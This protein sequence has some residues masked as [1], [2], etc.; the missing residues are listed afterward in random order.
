MNEY[1]SLTYLV[2]AVLV[3]PASLILLAL[4][5]LALLK[6]RRALGLALTGGSLLLLLVL[7]LPAVAFRLMDTLE[8]PPLTNSRA[9]GEVQAVVILAG[10]VSYNAVDWGGTSV[11]L[12]TLQRLRYGAWLARETRLP[13]LVT[14]AAPTRGRP[15]E[16]AMMRD[17]LRDEFGV[18]V[19]WVEDRS[20]HTGDNAKLS[21]AMLRA[22]GVTRIALVTSAFHM[23]RAQRVFEQTGLQVVPA[24]TGYLG[25]AGGTT[26]P[27]HFVPNGDS[28]RLSYLAL[29]ELAANLMYRIIDRG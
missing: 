9:V 22:A 25:T 1:L 15:G 20:R 11:S 18:P 3:P 8:G 27:E 23:P 16:A 7:S 2:G 29:R 6:R 21:A 13:V 19:R 24:R 5:G 14:G 17:I 4:L 28:L 12:F 26:R 10:G